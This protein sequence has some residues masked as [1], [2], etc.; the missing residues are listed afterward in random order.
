[1]KRFTWKSLV[2][3]AALMVVGVNGLNARAS[4][5]AL[6]SASGGTAFAFA[7]TALGSSTI[8]LH[9]R[10][11]GNFIRFDSYCG[12]YT[13][14]HCATDLY[15]C[16][17]GTVRSV[18]GVLSLTDSRCDRRIQIQYLPNQQNGSGTVV[19]IAGPG[20]STTF[21]IHSSGSCF[22]SCKEE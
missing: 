13:F 17:T 18:N 8:C 1:M 19:Y 7:L 14:S 9:D 4:L 5:P 2:L 12:S 3:T 6:P 16:G 11:T 15:L 22:C 10:T 20:V 21:P